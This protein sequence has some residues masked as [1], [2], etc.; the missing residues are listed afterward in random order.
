MRGQITGSFF[1]HLMQKEGFYTFPFLPASA[2]IS[3]HVARY[4]DQQ[5]E[6]QGSLWELPFPLEHVALGI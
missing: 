6:G 5:P 2:D 1:L 3:S 4:N